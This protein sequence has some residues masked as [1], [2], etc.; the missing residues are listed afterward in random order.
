MI[1]ISKYLKKIHLGANC[2]YDRV[3]HINVFTNIKEQYL[4]SFVR[5]Q[6]NSDN[7]FNNEV[8]Y[9]LFT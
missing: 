9:K 6:M 5:K 4:K 2:S 1:V 7:L 3:I 8:T